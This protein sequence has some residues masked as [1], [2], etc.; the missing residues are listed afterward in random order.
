MG[1]VLVTATIE[2]LEDLF[3]VQAGLLA[4]DQVRRIEVASRR[5]RPKA[6]R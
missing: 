5:Q 3:N 2:N 4:A 6:G 1:K